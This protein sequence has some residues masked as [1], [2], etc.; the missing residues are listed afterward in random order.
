[1]TNPIKD[2]HV[3]ALAISRRYRDS[4]PDIDLKLSSFSLDLEDATRDELS[5]L[6]Q[7][8]VSIEMKLALKLFR[9]PYILDEISEEGELITDEIMISDFIREVQ[10]KAVL[11]HH[12]QTVKDAVMWGSYLDRGCGWQ[13]KEHSFSEEVMQVCLVNVDDSPEGWN[14]LSFWAIEE[15]SILLD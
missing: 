4:N 5:V 8:P 14:N 13:Y 9:H 7:L 6:Q 11:M 1:M 10:G 2:S 3:G 15:S 12:W